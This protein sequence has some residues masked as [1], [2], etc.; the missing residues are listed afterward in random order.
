MRV[1][2][3]LIVDDDS[4]VRDA[5][6]VKLRSLGYA[7]ESA[8]DGKTGFVLVKRLRPALVLLD[9]RMPDGDGIDFL[10]TLRSDRDVSL[11]PV[12]LVTATSDPGLLAAASI[13]GVKA[14]IEKSATGL[15]Q[16]AERVRD[17][18]G[19]GAMHRVA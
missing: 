9:M 18:A 2:I 11:T 8:E 13:L 15:R 16:L 17:F 4:T 6:A 7:T 19:P 5:I 10:R 1:P 12:L 14:H 3:I